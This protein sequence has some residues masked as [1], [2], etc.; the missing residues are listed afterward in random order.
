VTV[1]SGL[2]YV[3]EYV[4]GELTVEWQRKTSF[5]NRAFALVTANFALVTFFFAI[6]AQ[7]KML[8]NLHHNPS[9]KLLLAAL[10]AVGGSIAF[11]VVA[12]APGNYPAAEVAGIEELLNDV[13]TDDDD[14]QAILEEIIRTQ[15]AQLDKARQTNSCKGFCVFV[16]FVALAIAAAALSAALILS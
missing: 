7:L 10:A 14:G 1:G 2:A 4:T 16:A 15:I 3:H 13:A 11:A 12:A 8:A 6:T 9:A 5:E